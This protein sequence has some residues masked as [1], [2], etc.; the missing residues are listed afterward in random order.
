MLTHRN[1]AVN[2]KTIAGLFR[3]LHRAGFTQRSVYPRNVLVQPGPLMN[4]PAER[5][6]NNPSYRIIDFGRAKNWGRGWWIDADG[7]FVDI[8]EFMNV[9]QERVNRM[10][11]GYGECLRAPYKS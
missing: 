2:R 6:F 4:P 11:D 10:F 8:D 3:R 7:N 5:S 1:A 9:E